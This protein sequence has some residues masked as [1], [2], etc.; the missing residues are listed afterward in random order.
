LISPDCGFDL[1]PDDAAIDVLSKEDLP[2]LGAP[3]DRCHAF[4]ALL[5][6][7]FKL[8]GG[9]MTS[10]RNCL[11]RTRTAK[12]SLARTEAGLKRRRISGAATS[13]PVLRIRDQGA[14]SLFA[15]IYWPAAALI[16][17]KLGTCSMHGTLFQKP[18]QKKIHST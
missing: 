8:I 15:D 17:F 16:T 7:I 10:T 9:R 13:R 14:T 2:G 1:N 11:C 5:I 12:G 4:G 18:T 6:E 3:G